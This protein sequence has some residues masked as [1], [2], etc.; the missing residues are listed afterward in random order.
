MKARVKTLEPL[1][2]YRI[3]L[4]GDPLTF[5]ALYCGSFLCCGCRYADL[6]IS[7]PHGDEQFWPVPHAEIAS[8]CELHIVAQSG[9]V[10]ADALRPGVEYRIAAASGQHR[11]IFAGLTI[12]R[13]ELLAEFQLRKSSQPKWAGAFIAFGCRQTVFREA[14]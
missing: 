7:S 11:G 14:V 13:G 5:D 4:H 6:L 8:A 1:T 12:Y 2:L 9:A 3:T 10:A